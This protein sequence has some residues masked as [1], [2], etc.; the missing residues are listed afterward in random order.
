MFIHSM[1][2]TPLLSSVVQQD[3][4]EEVLFLG[5]RRVLGGRVLSPP[6]PVHLGP[7]H[8]VAG[9]DPDRAEGGVPFGCGGGWCGVEVGS[10]A[11]SLLSLPSPSPCYT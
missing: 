11:L 1:S 4:V 7:G 2:I 9:E 8:V 6:L 3:P 10:Q 5:R